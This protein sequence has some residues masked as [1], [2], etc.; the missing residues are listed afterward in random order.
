[1]GPEHT[2]W[3]HPGHRGVGLASLLVGFMIGVSAC[4][5]SPEQADVDPSW[6]LLRMQPAIGEARVEV[7]PGENIQ[8]AID[9]LTASGGSV[10]LAP[11]E[12]SPQASLRLPSHT[13]LVAE[14]GSTLRFPPHTI[15]IM[16]ADTG[17]GNAD[18]L[19][20]GVHLIGAG[21]TDARD[22]AN[23]IAMF[24]VERA[25][26]EDVIVEQFDGYNIVLFPGTE[27]S[28]VV[29]SQSH[30]AAKEGI[31]VYGGRECVVFGNLVRGAGHNG[32]LVW[33]GSRDTL[34]ASNLVIDSASTG[35]YVQGSANEATQVVETRDTIIRNNLVLDSGF[36]GIRIGSSPI[37]R[38]VAI[39][40]NRILGSGQVGIVNATA[41][42][43]SVTI[44][45]NVV[46]RGAQG[47]IDAPDVPPPEANTLLRV[48]PED[49]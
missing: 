31:E 28:I 34:V 5:A 42:S 14:G 11:G 49:R 15:G 4:D 30:Q 3:H 12:W 44:A 32:I 35:I 10:I 7:A 43:S 41:D 48:P 22:T 26:I 6:S 37:V 18:I 21:W 33:Y 45:G 16:N 25:R 40:G 46:E 1:M 39:T 27:R 38:R 29:T 13:A 24:G 19:I 36:N 23:G 2:D 47:W 20:R 9:S 17:G 8:A